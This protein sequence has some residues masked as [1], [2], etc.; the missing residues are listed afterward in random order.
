MHSKDSQCS[1]NISMHH[2]REL[3][4]NQSK[5][6]E[7]VAGQAKHREVPCLVCNHTASQRRI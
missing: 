7:M 5:P 6:L 3:P 1:R 2:V 4:F